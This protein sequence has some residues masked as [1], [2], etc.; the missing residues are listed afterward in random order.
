MPNPGSADVS[1]GFEYLIFDAIAQKLKYLLLLI[2]HHGK[3]LKFKDLAGLSTTYL[4]QSYVANGVCLSRMGRTLPAL[5][6]ICL[7]NIPILDG[8]I[9]SFHWRDLK[10]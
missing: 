5:L 4:V 2:L 6:A 9:C 3:Q 10:S 7:M 8:P 1:G